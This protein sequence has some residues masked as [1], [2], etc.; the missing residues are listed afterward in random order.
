MSSVIKPSLQGFPDGSV[1][2]NPFAVQ[3]TG[4]ASSIPRSG[5]SR[6][7]N[8]NPAQYSCLKKIPWTED[9]Y[10][11]K[12]FEEMDVTEHHCVSYIS[13]NMAWDTVI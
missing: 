6:G 10:S 5:R 11:P 13:G 4:D 1:V 12:G 8:G 2:K 3:E 7:G 9:W